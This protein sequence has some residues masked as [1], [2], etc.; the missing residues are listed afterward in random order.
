M[1][2]HS[3]LCDPREEKSYAWRVSLLLGLARVTNW[4]PV[5]SE[6]YDCLKAQLIDEAIRRDHVIVTPEV[7]NGRDW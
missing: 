6:A 1:H 5:E 3:V 2:D 4:T 7:L